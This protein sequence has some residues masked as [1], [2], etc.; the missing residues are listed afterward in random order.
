MSVRT[1]SAPTSSPTSA[2]TS[3]PTSAPIDPAT[4]GFSSARRIT[5]ARHWL[6]LATFALATSGV[7]SF[8]VVAARIPALARHWTNTDMA[9]RVLVVH[10]DLAV[11]AWFVT[12]PVALCHLD[13]LAAGGSRRVSRLAALAPWLSTTGVLLLLAGLVPGLGVPHAVNYVP[14]VAHPLYVA[15]LVLLIGGAAV[16][17]LDRGLFG[18][19]ASS[20]ALSAER[21]AEGV[22][23]D[24][25]A[26]TLVASGPLIRL[27]ASYFWLA[28]LVS[29][30]AWELLPVTLEA[31]ARLEAVMWGG[32]HVLQ[33]AN[34]AFA[35][36]AWALLAAFASGQPVARATSLRWVW[37][38]LALPIVPIFVLA[39]GGAESYLY[40]SGFTRLMQ[41]GLFPAVLLFLALI[42]A[43]HF[44]SRAPVTGAHSRAALWPLVASVVLMLVGFLF[45]ALLRGSDLRIPGHYH[46]CIGAV[47]LAYM[48]LTLLLLDVEE[49]APDPAR[50]RNARDRTLRWVAALY[51]SGQLVF[52]TGLFVAGSYGLGRKT[53]G[54]EQQVDNF[55]Q[56][57][58]LWTMAV[59]GSLAL[60]GGATWA[61]A[62][63]RRLRAAR[64]R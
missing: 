25:V 2:P 53:Y 8:G 19:V 4:G 3:S 45:G 17:Y 12:L 55:G 21:E 35:L 24:V 7:L 30:V 39:L 60:A 59:G 26:T 15:G 20:A 36:V 58:G 44:R 42:L 40:R 22:R 34:V 46:A 13:L 54:I 18:R 9:R 51:C 38:V 50:A 23:T 31:A 57:T 14:L 5:L 62:A 63:L 16:S 64:G 48:A 29:G 41:W 61:V 52:S 32:G 1:A 56:R 37:V 49:I 28:I 11:V 47:T 27:G 43:P 33:F 6:G 10:V